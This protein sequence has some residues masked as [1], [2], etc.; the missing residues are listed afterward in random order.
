MIT[1]TASCELAGWLSK[2][3]LKIG[4]CQI[5]AGHERKHKAAMSVVEDVIVD[6][7]I[8]AVIDTL[9]PYVGA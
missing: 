1:K 3:L 4:V 7:P 5:A 6:I 9:R 2:K 8:S